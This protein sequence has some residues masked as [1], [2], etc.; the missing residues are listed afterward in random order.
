MSKLNR[1]YEQQDSTMKV[2]IIYDNIASVMKANSSLRHSVKH[3][4]INLQ[5]SIRPWQVDMLKFPPSAEESLTDAIDAHLIVLAGR[6]TQTFPFW[7]QDW[8]ENW[9]KCRQ[10]KDAALAVVGGGNAELLSSSQPDLSQFARRHGLS[11]IFDDRSMPQTLNTKNYDE[12]RNWG[13]NE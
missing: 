4:D 5:W 3:P 8:L 10:I 1:H 7:L 12:Y 13:I 11:I 9:A 6:C 2:V